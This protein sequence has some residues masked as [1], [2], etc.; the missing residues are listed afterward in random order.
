MQNETLQ[1]YESDKAL[2][3]SQVATAK[4]YPRNLEK[5][6]TNCITAITKS[7]VSVAE[8]CIYT[9]P[10][11][12]K[13]ISGPSVYLAK[14]IAQNM[15]NFKFGARVVDIDHKHVTSEGVAIDL[16][17]NISASKQVKRLI[18]GN[19]G[20][21]NEDM[22]TV[23]GNAANSIAMRNAIFDVVPQ[24][25]VDKVL[26]TAKRK[27]IGDISSEEKLIAR[28]TVIVDGFK[29]RYNVTEKEILYAAGKEAIE[30]IG[31]DE[32]L[33][34]IGIENAL[35][36]G[37]ASVDTVFKGKK[38]QT[39]IIE[40]DAVIKTINGCTSRQQ[41]EQFRNNVKTNAQRQAFD[42]KWE[43]LK[44]INTTK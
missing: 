36:A 32:I 3:D 13:K 4:A 20:R 5:C 18:I 22:I 11:S 40:D 24:W 26:D 44:P 28:R 15:Q 43:F 39:I 42:D 17:N 2:I 38:S 1:V 27:I 33:A 30:H 9:I 31:E 16:E 29:N 41:L 10:R 6:V 21:F 12:G 37:E 23:T 35:K 14:L 25:I 7:N 19:N 34:L 8:S